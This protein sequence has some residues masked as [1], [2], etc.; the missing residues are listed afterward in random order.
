MLLKRLLA[1]FKGNGTFPQ[2]TT[3]LFTG[4]QSV[5]VLDLI[6]GHFYNGPFVRLL[7]DK[8]VIGYCKQ[9]HRASHQHAEVHV[10]SCHRSRDRPEAEEEYDD[11]EDNGECVD[12]YSEDAGQV[13]RSPDELICFPCVVRNVGR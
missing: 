12:G 7:R 13:E 10:W 3:G 9:H 11:T 1:L 4:A 2:T 6:W 5:P 8:E